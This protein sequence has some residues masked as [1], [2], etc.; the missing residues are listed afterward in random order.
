VLYISE[1]ETKQ[2]QE[3]AHQM[4]ALMEQNG[5]IGLAAASQAVWQALTEE[6]GD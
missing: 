3:L 5:R 1:H 6:A 2:A 4:R